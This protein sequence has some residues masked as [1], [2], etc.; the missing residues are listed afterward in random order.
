MPT[1]PSSPLGS[2]R[3]R[4]P[5]KSNSPTI[6]TTITTTTKVP[7][8][9]HHLPR[10][11]PQ[12]HFGNI[13]GNNNP[14]LQSLAAVSQRHG[15][16]PRIEL[17]GVSTTEDS[18]HKVRR[19]GQPSATGSTGPFPEDRIRRSSR[20]P[21]HEQ[22][23]L[24]PGEDM[25]TSI[26]FSPD[27][28]PQPMA[29]TTIRPTKRTAHNVCAPADGPSAAQCS[30]ANTKS[31]PFL[32]TGMSCRLITKPSLKTRSSL[33]TRSTTTEANDH[34]LPKPC[35]SALGAD[36]SL[37]PTQ[38]AVVPSESCAN[39]TAGKDKKPDLASCP[40]GTPVGAV[41]NQMSAIHLTKLTLPSLSS[42]PHPSPGP[43]AS[44]GGA[45][46]S[47]QECVAMQVDDE[48]EEFIDEVE[49]GCIDEVEVGCSDDE[50]SDCS[51]IICELNSVEVPVE[52]RSALVPSL[53]SFFPPTLYFSKANERV[54]MLPQDQRK[55]LKWKM[56][57][58]TP[59]VVRH[60]IARSHF[61]I[62]KRSHDWLGCWGHHMKSP[63]FKNIKEHQKLN[64]FP[65]SFQIGRKDRLWRNLSKMRARFGKQEFSFFPRSFILPQDIKLLRRAWEDAGACHK[66]IIKP[67]AS[68]RG[69]GIEVIHKWCQ[70]PKKR[71]LLVQKYLHKPYLISGN[72]FDLR[73]YV[74]VT[75]YDPLRIYIF[76]DGLV[77]FASCKYSSS[78]R[79]LGN[80]F[81]HLTNYSVNKKNSEYQTNSDDKACQGHKWALKALWQYLGAKGINTTLIWDKIKDMVIKTIIASD[82][83]INSLLKM[84]LSAPYSCHELF[85]FD[86]MLDNKLKPWVLHSNTALDVTIKGQM[87][88]DVLNLAGF[89]LPTCSSASSSSRGRS[90]AKPS[91][92]EQDLC[93]SVL[94]VLTPGD[95]RRYLNILLSQWESRYASDRNKGISLLRSL[96]QKSVHLGTSDPAHMWSKSSFVSRFENKRADLSSSSVAIS[97]QRRIH[98]EDED[99]DDNE[100]SNEDVLDREVCS[101]SSSINPVA[102]P[103]PGSTPTPT[104]TPSPVP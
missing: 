88:R 12:V 17:G 71:P 1:N 50:S 33:S 104:P 3:L 60:I 97:W 103:S 75:S 81:M 84:H 15:E 44:D 69:T 61:K 37:R 31:L 96:C 26:A 6:T 43:E 57:S 4:T 28:Q 7:L 52:E 47:V 19:S 48:E 18:D 89:L 9:T 29:T 10:E 54:E 62:T 63:L 74:Y 49:D 73:I 70:M 2:G 42:S 27:N 77:R 86:I 67:P 32:A 23:A 55:L 39:T 83:Y 45:E 59:N 11:L 58:V 85:G 102:S 64:H 14:A 36:R 13:D 93:S 72:K 38:G 91:T 8:P 68:A 95:C 100:G 87:I 24:S 101:I 94:D 40:A 35:P 92:D 78:M 80:K 51:S 22:R 41:A 66:W 99:D 76:S 90:R 34:F 79:S 20:V 25:E 98:S 65:G 82:P 16:T 21:G 53:F 5:P 56:S 46:L 30:A